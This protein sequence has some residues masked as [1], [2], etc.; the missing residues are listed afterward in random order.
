[1]STILFTLSISLFDSIS[2]TQQI[3]IFVLFLTTI[4]PVRNALWYLAGLMGAYF[5]CGIAGFLALD[6]VRV[7][8]NRFLP[9]AMNMSDPSY[10]QSELFTGV[11]MIV[12]GIWYFRKK[13]DSRPGRTENM[14]LKRLR[15]MNSFASFGIGVIISI[16]SFPFS[17]PYLVALGKYSALHFGLSSAIGSIL[18]YNIGYA[19]PMIA[20]LIIY[21]IARRGAGDLNDSLHEKVR[22]LNVQLTTW[23][24]VGIGLFSMIDAGCYF[25]IGHALVKGRYF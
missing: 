3:I 1:M 13:K 25:T 17:I 8:L 9:S 18:V 15:S 12:I 24:L 2:T 14:L 19:L 10:Y 20:V 11:V 23:A 4:K 6:K 7:L 22:V 16:T 5:T 21:L